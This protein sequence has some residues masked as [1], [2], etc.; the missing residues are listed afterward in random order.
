VDAQLLIEGDEDRLRGVAPGRRLLRVD[1]D[2]GGP[3][4][5]AFDGVGCQAQVSLRHEVGV[6][7]VISDG[8]VLIGAGHPVDAKAPRDVVMAQRAPQSRRLD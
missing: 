3:L 1:A 2:L 4:G 6:D 8:A 7:V 5:V